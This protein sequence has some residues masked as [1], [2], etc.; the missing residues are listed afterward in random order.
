[1][2]P[3]DGAQVFR[4][5]ERLPEGAALAPDALATLRREQGLRRRLE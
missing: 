2:A 5:R 1:M 4:L 3:G